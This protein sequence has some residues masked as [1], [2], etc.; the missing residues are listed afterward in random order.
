M[1]LFDI[2]TSGVKIHLLCC[3]FLTEG[4]S[5]DGYKKRKQGNNIIS[6]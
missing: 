5:G 2:S 1:L 3:F 4:E 6:K